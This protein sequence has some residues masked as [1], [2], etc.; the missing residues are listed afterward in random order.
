MMRYAI[1]PLLAM[2]LS[3]AGCKTKRHATTEERSAVEVKAG[4]TTEVRTHTAT[5]R[6]VTDSLVIRWERL[7]TLGRVVER[8]TTESR[9]VVKEYITERDTIV[10]VDTLYLSQASD[11]VEEVKT[12]IKAQSL[13]PWWVWMIAVAIVALAILYKLRLLPILV[14]RP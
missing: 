7:D 3:L 14:R 5:H 4:A 12:S 6:L 13:V 10:V 1:I 9:P 2:G 8:S 11:R